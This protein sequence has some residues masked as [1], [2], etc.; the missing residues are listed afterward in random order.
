MAANANHHLGI[1]LSRSIVVEPLNQY[2]SLEYTANIEISDEVL[3]EMSR[4][5]VLNL[6]WPVV[7]AYI[8][9]RL[10]EVWA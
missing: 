1:A 3:V 2:I 7:H 8:R 9:T 5:G 4:Q 6:D 10:K